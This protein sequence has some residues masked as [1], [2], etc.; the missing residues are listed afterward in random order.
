MELMPRASR[1]IP[2]H[3]NGL[4]VGN[5]AAAARGSHGIMAALASC[6]PDLRVPGRA[7]RRAGLEEGSSLQGKEGDLQV[8]TLEP[9]GTEPACL[10]RDASLL[11]LSSSCCSNTFKFSCMQSGKT[12]CV[13]TS[14]LHSTGDAGTEC[15]SPHMPHSRLGITLGSCFMVAP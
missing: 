10:S 7:A 5:R 1:F 15:L 11:H 2:A 14:G 4:I 6:P 3:M 9:C 13:W 8:F 12:F